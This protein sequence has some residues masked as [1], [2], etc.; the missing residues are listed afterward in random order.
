MEFIGGYNFHKGFKGF[1]DAGTPTA[2][3][4]G[5]LHWTA[6]LIATNV[7]FGANVPSNIFWEKNIL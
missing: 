3:E 4:R 5:L 6:Y 2:S 1:D 7:I